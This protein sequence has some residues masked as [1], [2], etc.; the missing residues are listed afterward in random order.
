M[1]SPVFYTKPIRLILV[2]SCFYSLAALC[3]Q[4]D[5]ACIFAYA[6]D[7]NLNKNGLHVAWSIDPGDWHP[8]GPEHSYLQCDYGN[9]GS[10]KRYLPYYY[11]MLK[12]HGIA[13]GA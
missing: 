8:I 13:Y 1:L 11:M 3:N 4:P 7:K 9:W 6:T 5:S 2:I 10:E 12:I